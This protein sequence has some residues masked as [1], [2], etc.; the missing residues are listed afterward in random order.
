MT[1]IGRGGG[2][3]EALF[4]AGL[5]KALQVVFHSMGRSCFFALLHSLPTATTLPL[6]VLPP[7]ETGTM[8]SMVS[9]RGGNMR[10]Q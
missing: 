1:I 2:R 6:V 5:A 8:W 3:L 7:R 10:P 4:R 9:S